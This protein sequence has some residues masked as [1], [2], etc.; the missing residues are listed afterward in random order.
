MSADKSM[1]DFQEFLI[2]SPSFD[3][4]SPEV[5]DFISPFKNKPINPELLIQLYTK[6]RDHFLYDPYHLDLRKE[7]LKASK[8]LKKKRAWCVEKSLVFSSACRALGLPAKLGFATVINHLGAD[9]LE[10]YLGRKEITFH[11]YSVVYF[12]GKWLRC[13]PAFDSRICRLTGVPP[14]E[15]DAKSDSLFQK[16]VPGGLFM[17]YTHNYGEFADIP[18]DLMESEMRSYYPHLFE[19]QYNSREF[20]FH[21]SLSA[22]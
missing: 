21:H 8:V 16:E 17:E 7:A 2:E 4:T 20:S 22:T 18:F 10:E 13:T 6:V 5:Q 14:L 3:F 19:N 9:K 1:L 15:W 11:G 12:E